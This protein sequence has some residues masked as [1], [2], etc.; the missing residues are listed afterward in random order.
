MIRYVLAVV[1]AVALLAVA[2]PAVDRAA[3]QNAD[4]QVAASVA[5]IDEAAT[6]LATNEELSPPDHPDPRRVVDVA[7]PRES[8]TTD[9]VDRLEIEPDVEHGYSSVRY[10]LSDGTTSVGAIAEPIVAETAD[11]NRTV[12]IGGGDDLEL[13]LTLEADGSGDPVV[14][15]RWR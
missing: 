4:R 13:V 12:E 15:A 11:G 10:V 5:A 8:L 2:A 9:G 6:S 14:V 3:T 7:L 1:L